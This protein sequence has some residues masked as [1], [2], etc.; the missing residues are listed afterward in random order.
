MKSILTVRSSAAEYLAFASAMGEQKSSIELRYEDENLWLTQKIM[1]ELYGVSVAAINQHLKTLFESQELDN[2]VIKKFL[3][4]A[5][6]GKN[7]STKHYNLL[8]IISVGFKIENDRA[9]QFR[10]WARQI[11]KEYTIKGFAMDDERLKQRGS[12]LNK[13]FFEELLSRIR[14]I[15]LSERMFYQ[16][17][18][19][20]YSTAIDYDYSA[21]ITKD[22]FATVQ[23]KLHWAIH[24]QTASEVIIKRADAKK[25]YMGLTNWKDSP[26]GKI[27]KFDVSIAK[28]YLTETELA[29]LRRIVSAFLDLAEDMAERHIPMTMN[30]WVI[31]LDRFIKMADRKVL[32]D[33]GK[34]THELAKSFAETEFEKYRIT[35]D[36]LFESDFDLELKRIT[37]L[38]SSTNL[39]SA[40]GS[41]K[42]LKKMKFKR[43]KKV[44]LE[45]KS[46]AIHLI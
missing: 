2:S 36:R 8:A 9:V 44:A 22:F 15:R 3:I 23:N 29:S 45:E 12:I 26:K 21:K 16:K 18:T 35:Q 39:A 40:Y 1:A 32:S 30:D 7:Y 6:D 37:K 38:T 31:R 25:P 20:I 34:V 19:D 14:E 11:V 13:Q 33:A 17:I 24:G 27:Q 5:A 10:K 43:M 41:M 28:N 42:L 46:D 4:T